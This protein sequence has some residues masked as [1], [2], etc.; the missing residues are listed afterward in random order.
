MN[1]DW[2]VVETLDSAGD[3]T[4]I[5]DGGRRKSWTNPARPRP[6]GAAAIATVIDACTSTGLPHE[7]V[8]RVRG[9]VPKL[10]VAGMPVLGAYGAVHAVEVW[11]GPA[12]TPIPPRRRVAAW[13]W[14]QA[15]YV[16]V[17]G[18]NLEEWFHG[19]RPDRVRTIRTATENFRH[20]E[21]FDDIDGYL[22][23]V[24]G[25]FQRWQGEVTIRGDDGVRRHAQMVA[26]VA[27]DGSPVLRGL[28]HEITDVSPPEPAIYAD[29]ARLLG[30]QSDRGTG[31]VY[32]PLGHV[33]H[34][35][36]APPAPLDSWVHSVPELGDRSAYDAALAGIDSG[37]ERSS[38]VLA[39]RF[40]G[41]GW[42][43]VN[44]DL[45]RLESTSGSR[46]PQYLIQV[47]AS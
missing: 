29:V 12:N 17:H 47:R 1:T 38:C 44:V 9:D 7:Q 41:G 31:L 26:R 30:A 23:V 22:S 35:I 11:V 25:E 5:A 20:V 40:P 33:Y 37:D 10:L 14:D 36:T 2:L 6:G 16:A 39:V 21:R 18:P 15:N 27:T 3:P 13:E 42:H 19:T 46:V 24:T 4:V 34:W 32:V 8:I 28:F 43:E 45:F